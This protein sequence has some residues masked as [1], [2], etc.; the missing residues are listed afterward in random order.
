MKPYSLFRFAYLISLLYTELALHLHFRIKIKLMRATIN[1][2]LLPKL[3][4]SGKP[5]D[6]R[7]DKLTGFL[8]RVNISGKLVFM[9]EYTRGKRVTI[10]KADAL[11]P[12]Q[13]RDKAK[14]ILANFVK[15]IDPKLS[16]KNVSAITFKTFIEEDYAD[17]VISLPNLEELAF[18]DYLKPMVLH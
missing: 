16:K 14:E 15:G 12:M 11:T 8:I 3:K 1:N 17:W 9:C 13:A 4:P 5:Y 6:V 7:D 18:V 10:G 2:S